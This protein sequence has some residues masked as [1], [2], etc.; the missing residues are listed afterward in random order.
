MKSVACW[1]D[2]EPFGIVPLTGEACGLCYRLLFDLT[3]QGLKIVAACFGIP[4]LKAGEPWN[5]GAADDPH[6]GSI[7]LS[8]EMLVPV[9]VFALLETGCTEAWHVGQAVVGIETTD[10]EL[11]VDL[12]RE[13]HEKGFRRRLAYQGTAGSRNRHVMSGRV[14]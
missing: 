14:A 12:L 10:G 4:E 2:L 9:A 6:V 11:D 7:M 1:N 3:A 5:R 13:F 8:A